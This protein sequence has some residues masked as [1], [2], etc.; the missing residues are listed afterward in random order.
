MSRP[1]S[2]WRRRRTPRTTTGGAN[3][4]VEHP[5]TLPDAS[6]AA[7]GSR[8][9]APVAGVLL[10]AL[11]V[12]VAA[13]TAGAV[14]ALD[15]TPDDPPPRVSMSFAVEDRTLSFTHRGGDAIDV[16]RLRLVVEIEG[17]PLARQPP[18][19]F[20]S[21]DGFRSGPTGPFNRATDPRWTAG[22]TATVGVAATNRPRLATGDV[23]TV[24]L[25]V[26]DTVVARLRA[27]AS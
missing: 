14:F 8:A 22:E 23:V 19:P 9:L 16:S 6:A 5:S 26:D 3:A 25:V 4:T 10:L 21:A 20:F 24:Q 11:T 12:G 7:N 15:D 17:E 1:A 27:T 13:A 18:V 2:W